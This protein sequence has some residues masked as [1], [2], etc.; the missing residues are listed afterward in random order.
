MHRCSRQQ[1]AGIFAFT[2]RFRFASQAGVDFSQDNERFGIICTFR[3]L[4]AAL[5]RASTNAF[6]HSLDRR[7]LE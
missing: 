2:N 1:C 5:S 7:D 4:A 6:P 3:H